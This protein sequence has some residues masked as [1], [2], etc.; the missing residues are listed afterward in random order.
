MRQSLVDRRKLLAD[1]P[2]TEINGF[3]EEKAHPIRL[4]DLLGRHSGWRLDFGISGLDMWGF[5]GL[6]ERLACQRVG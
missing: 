1:E 3:N 5:R 6:S 4:G 2:C